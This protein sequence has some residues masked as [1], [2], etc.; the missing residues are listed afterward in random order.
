[1]ESCPPPQMHQAMLPQQMRRRPKAGT[2]HPKATETS[3]SESQGIIASK[4]IASQR[5]Q[6]RRNSNGGTTRQA[7]S[8]N[9]QAEEEGAA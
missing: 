9:A 3:T 7:S 2:H 5:L 6:G 4:E 8:T 1:M